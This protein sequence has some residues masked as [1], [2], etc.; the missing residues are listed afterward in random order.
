MNACI[1]AYTFYE[2][3]YR[4]RRYA[5]ALVEQGYNVDVI[6]LRR[7][8]EDKEGILNKV[9]IYRLQ[10]RSFK[11]KN[12]ISFLFNQLKF[13]ILGSMFLLTRYITKR[14]KIIHIHNI[15]D[16]LIF[17]GLI[18]K[19]TGAKLILDIHDIVPE[20]YCQKFNKSFD[21]S[22]VKCLLFI[23]KISVRF[24]DHV[25]VANDIW[26]EKVIKRD[27]ISPNNC[28]TLLNY[29][30]LKFFTNTINKQSNGKFTLIYPGTISEQHGL[31]VAIKTIS[32]VKQKIQTI[33]LNIYVLGGSLF[34]KNNIISMVK[35][36]GLEENVTFF[37]PV[38]PES[39]GKIMAKSDIGIVPKRGGIFSDEAFSTKILEFM[40]AGIPVVASKTSIDKYYFDDSMIKFFEVENPGDMA[41][42]ICELYE[43]PHLR[44]NLTR[45]SRKFIEENNWTIKKDSYFK[46]VSDLLLN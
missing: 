6:V 20:Y 13:F 42:C 24:A 16:F 14:Y 29:P 3:D 46:I 9:N 8:N 18:P 10:E 22:L 7:N 38:P 21:S 35:R 28:T 12:I 11:E 41:R 34:L 43:K 25:I 45:N 23:E 15:P 44:D 30:Q 1:I 2:L 4:V 31:D 39:L 5:E 37:D 19:L 27:S 32:I 33:Q 36:L 40:A 26:R 17:M